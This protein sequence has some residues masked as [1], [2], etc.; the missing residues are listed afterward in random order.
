MKALTGESIIWPRGG[1]ED[2]E[3]GNV[4]QIVLPDQTRAYVW[5]SQDQKWYCLS[6][7]TIAAEVPRQ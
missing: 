4:V 1:V 5:S 6:H 3:D 7:A 2:P